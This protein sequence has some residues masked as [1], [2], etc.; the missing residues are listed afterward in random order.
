MYQATKERM[1]ADGNTPFGA[2]QGIY[3]YLCG[4][5]RAVEIPA[6]IGICKTCEGVLENREEMENGG[7]LGI[8]WRLSIVIA[9]ALFVFAM[10]LIAYRGRL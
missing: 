1:K 3:V 5:C 9:G 4:Q 8:L 10:F 6:G 2:T 7:D